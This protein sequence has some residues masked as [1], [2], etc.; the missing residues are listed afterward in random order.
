MS[1][2]GIHNIHTRQ[3]PLLF[4]SLLDS[5]TLLFIEYERIFSQKPKSDMQMSAAALTKK[6]NMLQTEPNQPSKPN[7]WDNGA[8]Q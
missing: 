5:C 3:K 2:Y 8:L 4:S 6:E 1:M 7:K